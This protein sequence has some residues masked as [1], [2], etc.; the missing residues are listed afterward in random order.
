MQPQLLRFY[1]L[2]VKP[3]RGGLGGCVQFWTDPEA[4]PEAFPEALSTG[5]P[6]AR[7]VS[8]DAWLTRG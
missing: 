4:F 5:H 2:I 1:G 8:K 3:A 6:L 7:G